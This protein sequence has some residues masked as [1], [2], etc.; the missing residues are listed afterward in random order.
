Q[1]NGQVK[2]AVELLQQVVKI[3]EATLAED[4]PDRLSSQHVLA[5]AYEANGQV[6]EAVNLLEQVVKIREATLA[7][8]HP[9]RLASQYALAIA[10]KSRSRRRRH[11]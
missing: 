3:R 11:A 7:E 8:D 10:K 4:H 9:S 6:K 1:A 2:E 5:G